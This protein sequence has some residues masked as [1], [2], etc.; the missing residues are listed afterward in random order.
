MAVL[1]G[2]NG[3]NVIDGT[4]FDDTI[5]GLEGDDTLNGAD[6]NDEIEGGA[7]AD[8]MDG[9]DG[10]DTL[11]Y[12][13]SDDAVIVDLGLGTAS[14]GHASGDIFSSFENLLGSSFND[15]L[16]GSVASGEVISG[17]D[18]ADFLSG[19]GGTDSIYGG[20]GADVLLIAA[21]YGPSTGAV[22]DGG[23]DLDNLQLDGAGGTVFDLRDDTVVDIEQIKFISS[24]GGG[25]ELV[26]L[27]S[28]FTTSISQVRD[29]TLA[30][31]TVQVTLHMGSINSLDL[32]AIAFLDFDDPRDLVR[33]LGD[34]DDEQITGSAVND[35]IEGGAGAD[36]LDGDDGDDILSYAGSSAGVMIDLANSTASGGDATGDTFIRFEGLLGSAYSD[37][38]IGDNDD[39]LIEGGAGA[40]I[41]DGAGGFDTLTY[42]NAATGVSVDFEA[43][44][45]LAG[46][47]AGDT[48]TDFE[49]L[50]GSDFADTLTGSAGDDTIEGLGGGD[51]LDGGAGFDILSYRGSAQGVT[52][53]LT[54]GLFAG[55]DAE[56]DVAL[57]FEMVRGS[58]RDDSIRGSAGDDVIIGGTG[59]DFLDGAAG[60]DTVSYAEAVSAV[61]VNL[62][63]GVGL[64][65]EANGDTVTGF[66][67]IAGSAFNDTLFGSLAGG[68]TIH[69]GEG[70]DY[71]S[72]AGGTDLLFGEAGDDIFYII[73]EAF[74]TTGAI[75]DG[76]DGID[77]LHVEG[78]GETVIDLRDDTV[79]GVE[80][81]KFLSFA[82]GGSRLIMDARLLVD[83]FDR[84]RDGT[85]PGFEVQLEL[86][87]GS[88]TSLD[89]SAFDFRDFNDLGDR[90]VIIGDGDDETITGSA[91]NDEIESGGGND[92]LDGGAGLDI[93]SFASSTA[94]VTVD[95][96]T[97]SA[98]GGDAA[99]VSFSNFEGLRG[100]ALADSLTGDA[101][102]N[103][104]EGGDGADTLAGGAGIDI[105]SYEHSAAGVAVDLTT[106]GASGGDADGDVL[107]GFEG[108]RGSAFDDVL[109]GGS[110]NDTLMGLAGDDV[111]QGNA[112]ADTLD[113][114]A[115]NDTLDYSAS[116][117]AVTL[118]LTAG[119]GLGGDAGGDA[120][121]N[122][123]LFRGSS[124][125]DTITGSAAAETILGGAGADTLDGG[126]GAD[127]VSYAGSD[128]GV[129]VDLTTGS[130]SGGHA[131]GDT[132]SGF[133]NATGSDFA[134]TLIAGAGSAIL[135]GGAGND[136]LE[137][138]AG[139]DLLI[140]GLGDDMLTG[141]AGRDA[142][143]YAD[144][145]GGVT[146]SLKDALQTNGAVAGTDTLS[147]IEDL[148]GSAFND[149]LRG[150][151]GQNTLTGGDGDDLLIGFAGIDSLIGG[152]GNDTLNGGGGNDAL[153]GGDGMDTLI[154]RFGNDT[155]NGGDGNDIIDGGEGLDILYGDNG[156]D[157]IF[158]DSGADTLFGGAGEDRLR[159]A[160]GDDTLYGG[161]D[162]DEL[163]GGGKND[164]LFGGEGNDTLFGERGED[165]L[166]GGAGNDTLSGADQA[167][168]LYG[169]A[170][171]DY[172]N[173]GLAID[174]LDGGFGNDT[175][176][177]GGG[178]DTLF[179]GEGN[180]Q[181]LGQDGDDVLDGGSGLDRLNGGE[182]FDVLT[183]GSGADWFILTGP[184]FDNDR[185]TDFE[186]GVDQIVFRASTGIT[187]MADFND[188]RQAGSDVVIETDAGNVRIEN[189]DIADIDAADFIFG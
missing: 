49:G 97:G 121:V 29:S 182:G 77:I 64:L 170:G 179:G 10:I 71:I 82:G 157:D 167:D 136:V 35:V 78:D 57:N 187:S 103:I 108:L 178:N 20:A 33:I 8:T 132:L 72:G 155:I 129:S 144:A 42:R 111:V 3:A 188:M 185:I 128:A 16:F 126:G 17:A 117:A 43:G 85:A 39:N 146:V 127:T 174:M 99:N 95:L 161:A 92:T 69:G 183:G 60:Y 156:D 158:A 59:G 73:P 150:D 165:T 30:G 56:G 14:G 118:D 147:G 9:G 36:D 166:Y 44:T 79:D 184:N 75:Y 13:T 107:S 139:N 34:G 55:G 12:S 115:G 135:D 140:G 163:L 96:S 94:G 90:V 122:F 100:S 74:E 89:L 45:G 70:S 152:E 28:Q 151:N 7:G 52:I 21:A 5:S 27:A 6:G 40:D 83:D 15:T 54:T 138:N 154:G 23:A 186:D 105:L 25:S 38:L 149:E 145:A 61:N 175:L 124:H 162:D 189:T 24:S 116:S 112:G 177:G 48:F 88:L 2:D 153:V 113:G 143:S 131:S 84:V 160:G 22:Y 47:A 50:E 141:G 172:L 51:R 142:A 31:N 171:D 37:T 53:D 4:E 18:G 169:D 134:D 66:E 46:D 26:L 93:L 168:N 80:R 87:M 114:G 133:E 119:T 86:H 125:D 81:I 62:G 91:V 104:I 130:V 65:G 159:G 11:V 67:A 101:G 110:G 98:S 1:T 19:G 109:T 41:M 76:G 58:A 180:D 137:G 176:E 102:D 181:L 106:G 68:E 164:L 120:F 32:T 173:G 148:V 63:L 123:E